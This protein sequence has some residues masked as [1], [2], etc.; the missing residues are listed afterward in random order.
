MAHQKCKRKIFHFL[1][2]HFI[3]FYTPTHD[4]DDRF[5]AGVPIIATGFINELNCGAHLAFT[6][7]IFSLS[8]SCYDASKTATINLI[9]PLF[10]FVRFHFVFIALDFSCDLQLLPLVVLCLFFFFL[11]LHIDISARRTY[12]K[13]LLV[14]EMVY[15]LHAN[16]A[17]AHNL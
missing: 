9:L 2:S 8:I 17:H 10:G 13:R 5:G 12:S 3:S 15:C 16:S 1:S 7:S 4:A 11:W 14:R 6:I